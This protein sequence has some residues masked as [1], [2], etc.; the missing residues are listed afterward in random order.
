MLAQLRPEDRVAIVTYAG[1]AGEVLAPTPAGEK[2][3]IL[4]ALGR[5]AAGGS[6]A[7][8]EGLMQ[9]YQVAGGMK[10]EG[11]VTRILLATDGD[12]N[13]GISDPE[14]LKNFVAK[15]RASGTYLSVLGFGRGNLDDATMQALA[16]NG[17][18]T[19]AYID[20][21]SE[22]QLSLIHI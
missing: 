19:A 22:A 5:L 10:S 7:G 16:Q 15:E 1:S 2:D 14:E 9:A 13:V 3:K 18:G 11:S 4:D 8:Q 20:T 6:T 21:L 12:F 17:N